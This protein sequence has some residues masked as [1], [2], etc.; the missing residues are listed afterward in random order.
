MLELSD[1]LLAV[2]SRQGDYVNRAFQ[3]CIVGTRPRPCSLLL[4]LYLYLHLYL[5]LYLYLYYIVFIALYCENQAMRLFAS[6]A[7]DLQKS[8]NKPKHGKTLSPDEL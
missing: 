7:Q 2:S 3:V 8:A 6:F 4:H 1:T 5:C